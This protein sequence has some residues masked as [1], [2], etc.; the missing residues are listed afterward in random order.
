MLLFRLSPVFAAL[1]V[2]EPP[3]HINI[4]HGSSVRLDGA[5]LLRLV[6]APKRSASMPSYA[7]ADAVNV[8]SVLL[9]V[10]LPLRLVR[11]V[12]RTALMPSYANVVRVGSV[13]LEGALRLH[14]V[15][16]SKLRAVMPHNVDVVNHGLVH[17]EKA[18]VVLCPLHTPA[19]PEHPP[20]PSSARLLD[21]LVDADAM[22]VG[23]VPL[24]LASCFA[25]NVQLG[26]GY[27]CQVTSMP[28]TL[29][30]CTLTLPSC[31]ALYSHPS[32][33][34]ACHTMSML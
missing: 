9:D 19:N 6:L 11:A 2:T 18:R 15:L 32:S 27:S 31:F 33:G 12:G 25:L 7:D 4:V 29:A 26:S 13:L 17:L 10:A 14:L 24:D 23:S 22:H 1:D 30:L 5:L 34:Q 3:E 28:C 20:R 21:L 8:G 16:A